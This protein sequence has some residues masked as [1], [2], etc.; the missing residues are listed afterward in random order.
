MAGLAALILSGGR[1][2]HKPYASHASKRGFVVFTPPF[3]RLGRIRL[4]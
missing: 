3:I 2:K 4:R 1:Y